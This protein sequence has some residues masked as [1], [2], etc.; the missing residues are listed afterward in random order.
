MD[1]DKLVACSNCADCGWVCENH[2]DHPWA[3]LA[4][5]DECCGGAGM[6]CAECNQDLHLNG[7]EGGAIICSVDE[8]PDGN[9]V[10]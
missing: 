8:I 10:H 5:V 9:R 6:P 4:A 2:V 3:G 1:R 7:F